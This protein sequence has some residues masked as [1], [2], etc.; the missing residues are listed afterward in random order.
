VYTEDTVTTHFGPET[1]QTAHSVGHSSHGTT[2]ELGYPVKDGNDAL[3]VV[4]E[5]FDMHRPAALPNPLTLL[6]NSSVDPFF[7]SPAPLNEQ[8]RE[9]LDHGKSYPD[10]FN[11]CT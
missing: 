3:P 8:G 6:P 11:S 9:A 2:T 4:G 7:K 1:E 5:V 10:V